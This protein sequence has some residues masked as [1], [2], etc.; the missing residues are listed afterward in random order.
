MEKTIIDDLQREFTISFPPQRVVST[1]PSITELIA[2]L[3]AE[4]QLVG[5]TRFCKDPEG[6]KSRKNIIGSTKRLEFEKIK[7]LN[8]DLIIGNKEE[9]IKSQ[10]LDI[11]S[12]SPYYISV[13]ESMSDN[14]RLI[15][16]TGIILDKNEEAKILLKQTNQVIDEVQNFYQGRKRVA[17]LIWRNPMMLASKGT[18][19]NSML[20]LLG[21]ENAFA[22]AESRY[23]IT[24]FDELR[25][26]DLDYV[27]LS[28]IP[29]PFREIHIQEFKM[30]LPNVDVKLVDGEVFSYYGSR[31]SKSKNYLLEKLL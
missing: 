12:I 3:N 28:S 15:K 13:V 11:T 27:F 30:N 31:L 23:P 24:S 14:L 26:A 18:Y 4:D 10:V 25:N 21:F 29:F 6:L 17:Y 9:N 5:L 8:P 19:I 1:V 16:N 2:D 7:S 20:E 22:N